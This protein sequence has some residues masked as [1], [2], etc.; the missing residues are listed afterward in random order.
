VAPSLGNRRRL[1]QVPLQR[2]RRHARFLTC[3]TFRSRRDA[4]INLAI[5]RHAGVLWREDTEAELQRLER[6][7]DAVAADEAAPP[8]ANRS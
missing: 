3:P 4:D 5:Y 8:L 7:L 2:A 1:D 6:L